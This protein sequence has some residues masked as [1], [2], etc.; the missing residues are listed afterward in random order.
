M[1]EEIKDRKARLG[2]VWIRSAD[3]GT[4]YLCPAAHATR[5]SSASDAEL[6]EFGI[7]ESLN[8]QND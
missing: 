2:Y 4:T 7:D 3:S 5:L 1:F 6:R 8:P